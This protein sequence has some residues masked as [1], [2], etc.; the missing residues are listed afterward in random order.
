MPTSRVVLCLTFFLA[1]VVVLAQSPSKPSQSQTQSQAPSAGTAAPS[2]SDKIPPEAVKQTNP[3]KATAESIAA[4]K[5]MYGYD[6]AMCHGANGDGK[7]DLAAD[8]KVPIPDF[9]DAKAM[10]GRTDGQLFYIIKNGKGQMPAEGNRAK[11]EQVWDMVNYV[12]SLAKKE[13]GE[14]K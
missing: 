11:P 12:R 4:G 6:C 10:Q 14:K 2:A 8:L 7:G 5:R 9:R 13:S 1:A 3:V